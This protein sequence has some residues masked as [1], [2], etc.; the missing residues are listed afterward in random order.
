MG[1]AV[2]VEFYSIDEI[3]DKFLK[4]AVIMARYKEKWIFVRHE[5]R[6]T[7]EIPGGRREL[8]ESIDDTANR[9][10]REE[11]GACEYRIVPVCIYA[12]M[13]DGEPSYG[14]LYFAEILELQPL[15][16]ESEIFEI[17]FFDTL[18]DKLTYEAIQPALFEK[19]HIWFEENT[20]GDKK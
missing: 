1:T 11:T 8:V 5:N 6:D 9:E 18:P 13:W 4:Y 2:S 16:A 7:Y 14:A 20:K 19:V 10:L 3:P 15:P 12:V 17:S